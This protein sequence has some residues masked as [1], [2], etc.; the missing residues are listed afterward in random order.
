[1]ADFSFCF[2]NPAASNVRAHCRDYTKLFSPHPIIFMV[3]DLL[4]FIFFSFFQVSQ[5]QAAL[6]VEKVMYSFSFAVYG[7]LNQ[8]EVSLHSFL[9][10]IN[11]SFS[12]FLSKTIVLPPFFLS[13]IRLRTKRWKER[14]YLK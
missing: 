7:R 4:P 10:P 3:I 9:P 5:A 8:F 1:V 13:R 11:F 2:E 6:Q 12:P 14:T